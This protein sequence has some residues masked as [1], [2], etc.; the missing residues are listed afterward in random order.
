VTTDILRHSR[1]GI[2]DI[3]AYEYYHDIPV[4]L[5]V[6]NY[7]N[8]TSPVISGVA[9]TISGANISTISYSVD[10]GAFITSGVTGTSNF[11]IN[12]TPAL[13]VGTHSIQVR[14]TDSD[15]YTTL[16]SHYGSASFN[17]DTSAPLTSYTNSSGAQRTF[18]PVTLKG[19]SLVTSNSP[20]FTFTRSSDPGSGIAKYQI[21]LKTPSRDWYTYIDD[22]PPNKADGTIDDLPSRYVSYLG[23]EIMIYL[24]TNA[25]E[26]GPYRWKVR[27]IDQAG[28][29]TDTQEQVFLVNTHQA[30]FT[31]NLFFPLSILS[32]GRTKTNISSLNPDSTPKDPLPILSLTPIFYGIAPVNYT[33][34][35]KITPTDTGSNGNSQPLTFSTQVNPDSRFGINVTPPLDSGDYTVKLSATND[36]GDYVEIPEFGVE[37]K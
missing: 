16:P 24:K 19:Y 8:R 1:I 5:S 36:S 2:N 34:N 7:T 10:S 37:I 29:T 32:I 17:I 21:L 22:I 12:V 6:P 4:T 27:A 18:Q 26:N 35:L 30:V 3:G 15:G 31:P 9:S 28:N 33:V 23:D 14:A 13:N 20:A 25:L 11:N